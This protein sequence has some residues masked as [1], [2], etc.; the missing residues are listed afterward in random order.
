M[1]KKKVK[2]A[3]FCLTLSNP[4]DCAVHGILQARILE[5]VAFLSPGDLPNPGIE[6]M[7]PASQADSLPAEPPGKARTHP[8]AYQIHIQTH[9]LYFSFCVSAKDVP[10]VSNT[11][12]L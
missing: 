3:Q 6:P 7:S 5:W 10:F 8:N 1:K 12:C 4:M 11:P 2:V 9:A